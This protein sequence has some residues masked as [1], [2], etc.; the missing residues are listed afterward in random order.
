LTSLGNKL[1]NA[2][3]CKVAIKNN[4]NPK[5]HFFIWFLGLEIFK[6]IVQNAMSMR[7]VK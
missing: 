2:K 5:I 6:I 1:N 4:I 3:E 7:R